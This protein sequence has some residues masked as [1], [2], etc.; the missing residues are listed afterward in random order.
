MLIVL[1]AV[2]LGIVGPDGIS[3]WLRGWQTLAAAL[4]ASIAAYIA[5]QNTSR[6]LAHAEQLEKNRRGRKHAAL[7]ATLPLALA[8][9]SNY[10]EQSALALSILI[11]KCT[12]ETLP[13]KTA[14]KDLARSLPSDTLK[15]LADFIEY[16]DAIDV[17]VLEATVAWIQI[18]DSRVRG[19][20]E[21]NWD[22]A[23][24]RIV[25]RSEIEGSIVD[26]ASIYAGVAAAFEYAR[27]RADVLPRHLSW[28]DVRSALRNIRYWEDENPRL[29]DAIKRREA[30]SDGPFEKLK[31]DLLD[32][33][34]SPKAR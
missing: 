17:S 22:D 23:S 8:Q 26:A 20:A 33:K 15:S 5:F 6:S 21:N 25:L 10:A 11:G 34:V 2:A 13:L 32:Q 30:L 27:R 7:R 3:G 24:T 9:V 16:S 29:Y 31:L 19:L 18:H 4:V 1:I 12:G 14:P 28:D